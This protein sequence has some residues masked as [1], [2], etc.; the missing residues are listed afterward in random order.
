MWSRSL[1]LSHAHSI[2]LRHNVVPIAFADSIT[3]TIALWREQVAISHRQCNPGSITT[4]SDSCDSPW[5]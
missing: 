5:S 4:A 2:Q 1:C 3:V